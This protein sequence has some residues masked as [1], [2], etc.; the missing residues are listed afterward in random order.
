MQTVAA[1]EEFRFPYDP[2]DPSKYEDEVEDSV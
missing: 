1:N 2:E